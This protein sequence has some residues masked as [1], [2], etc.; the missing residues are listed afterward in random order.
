M[1]MTS[2]VVRRRF[3]WFP[4]VLAVGMLLAA[5]PACSGDGSSFGP[6]AMAG[7]LLPSSEVDTIYTSS[8]TGFAEAGRHVIRTQEE[9]NSFWD[10]LQGHLM[11]TPPVPQVDLDGHILV[12]GAMGSRPSGGYA[13]GVSAVARDGDDLVV[14]VLERS[15]GPRCITLGVITHPVTVVRIPEPS[16]EV[17]FHER[18]ETYPCD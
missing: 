14:E 3:G 18:S 17:R 8:Q 1:K 15:P 11:P 4:G 6:L 16:G 12:L 13:I 10:V 7:D 2:P 9:W 5:V